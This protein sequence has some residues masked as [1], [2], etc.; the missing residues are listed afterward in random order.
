MHQRKVKD[1]KEVR[2]EL[3][4][5]DAHATQHR[6]GTWGEKILVLDSFSMSKTEI[7]IL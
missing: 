3:G 2:K 5:H 6:Q 1:E 4:V 7:K